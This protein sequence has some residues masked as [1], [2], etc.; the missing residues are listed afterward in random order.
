MRA[1]GKHCAYNNHEAKIY[2]SY[3]DNFGEKLVRGDCHDVTLYKIKFDDPE[4]ECGNEE[5]LKMPLDH[6]FR[7]IAKFNFGSCLSFD[8]DGMF[9]KP[10]CVENV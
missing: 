10:T 8:D 2:Y 9:A 6:K 3:W 4:S 1:D 5:K 7:E